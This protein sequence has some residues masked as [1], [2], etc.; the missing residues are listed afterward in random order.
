MGSSGRSRLGAAKR[1]GI[2]FFDKFRCFSQS[3]R[4]RLQ[5]KSQH[6]YIK[7][8]RIAA[9][10]TDALDIT[11]VPVFA[12]YLHARVSDRCDMNEHALTAVIRLYKAVAAI[13][14]LD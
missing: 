1:C 4:S 12:K 14:S 13:F 9:A 8:F 3:E 7:R 5:G 6:Y 11:H 2:T 10:L